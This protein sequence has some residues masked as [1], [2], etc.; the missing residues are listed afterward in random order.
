MAR[1]IMVRILFGSSRQGRGLSDRRD[2]LADQ[3]GVDQCLSWF[4]IDFLVD[5]EKAPEKLAE[6]GVPCSATRGC[7]GARWPLTDELRGAQ[8]Y[9]KGSLGV[10]W[11]QETEISS[12]GL[13]QGQFLVAK[14]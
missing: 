14:S 1:R 10:N 3:A 8:G 7:H 9:L 5:L 2:S 12:P 4:R 13:V 11:S 6:C